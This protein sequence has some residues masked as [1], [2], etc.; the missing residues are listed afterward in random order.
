[1]RLPPAMD[2]TVSIEARRIRRAF[3]VPRVRRRSLCD[4]IGGVEL[5]E[6]EGLVRR[7]PSGAV[8]VAFS[9]RALFMT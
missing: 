1:V 8:D 6:M 7:L 9:P 3:F 2:K 5:E 4:G